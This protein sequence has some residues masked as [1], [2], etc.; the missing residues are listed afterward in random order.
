MAKYKPKARV[1]AFRFT[2]ETVGATPDAKKLR[3]LIDEARAEALREFKSPK[4]QV[5][6]KPD[7]G[8]FGA[9]L[10]IVYLLHISWPYI[11]A[12]GKVIATGAATEAGKQMFQY[13]SKALRKRDILPSDPE[14]VAVHDAA[15]PK[16]ETTKP[17]EK[18]KGAKPARKR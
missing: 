9:G 5:S 18:K 6:V 1:V 11:H 3:T 12:A 2:V 4:V 7:G 14:S 8:L 16:K 15:E 13:F 10:E 17:R